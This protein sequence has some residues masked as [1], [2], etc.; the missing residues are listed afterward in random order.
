MEDTPAKPVDGKPKTEPGGA[1]TIPSIPGDGS[2]GP[3]ATVS[4]RTR[5]RSPFMVR[6]AFSFVAT[7][8]LALAVV[9]WSEWW[10]W[11]RWRP[12]DSA[13]GFVETVL[14][15]ALVVQ[16]VRFVCARW[17]VAASGAG[18]WRRVF[19]AGAL[20]GWLVEGVLVTTV[21][22]DLPLT[23]VNT[24]LSWHALFTVLLGW[25]WMP[26]ALAASARSSLVALVAVGIGVGGWASFW[27]FEEGAS[28]SVPE[29]AV[30]AALTTVG[31]AVGLALW[32]WMRWRARPGLPG[33][34]VAMLVLAVFS[35]AY[36]IDRPL[37]LVGPALVGLALLALFSTRPGTV[38]PDVL[39]SAGP[40]PYRSLW[41][42]AIIPA[43]AVPVF[44]AFAALP[45]PI[46][47][48]WP[49]F[50]VSVV[51]GTVLFVVAW[52][53]A[54]VNARRSKNQ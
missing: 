54:A 26:R 51:L 16:I 48:G 50:A 46:P 10:F 24:A 4:A 38:Q 8:G 35:V 25:W 12:E 52:L 22:D 44:A 37:T 6:L 15:Y 34:I 9:I 29:Y 40:A 3:G 2:G 31:Y 43:V 33:T 14:G 11:G 32:W 42:L 28:P 5:P 45:T 18:A 1:A 27:R 36:A 49:V 13:L 41:R 7:I 19:L 53:A 20:Y 23:L 17:G 30:F 47:T 39:G 21:I